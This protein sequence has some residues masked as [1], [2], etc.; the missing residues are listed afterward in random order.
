MGQPGQ[1][2]AVDQVTTD[3]EQQVHA[4]ETAAERRDAGVEQD[5][6][7][8]G[9]GSQAVYFSSV[10]HGCSRGC[11]WAALRKPFVPREGQGGNLT[12]AGAAAFGFRCASRQLR[13]GIV[14]VEL[15]RPRFDVY[16]HV[17]N[18]LVNRALRP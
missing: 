6:R 8:H 9:Q 7:Q 3:D 10:K 12:G 5:D 2:V 4:D 17:D 1:D 16:T 14:P 18:F 11:R 15:V 13:R